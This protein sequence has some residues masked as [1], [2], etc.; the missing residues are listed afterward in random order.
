[1]R[2][3]TV[4]D[5]VHVNLDQHTTEIKEREQILDDVIADIETLLEDFSFELGEDKTAAF[6][7]KINAVEQDFLVYRKSFE[8]RLMELK[9]T[10]SMNSPVSLQ[11]SS[12]ANQTLSESLQAR[13][14]AAKRKIKAK[15]EAV[16]EDL[17]SLSTRRLQTGQLPQISVFEGR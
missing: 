3:Y 5:L 7:N 13:Q 10:P 17:V 1:M 15:L 6:Q 2:M 8:S 4:S 11:T 14:E 16:M 9:P 12:L